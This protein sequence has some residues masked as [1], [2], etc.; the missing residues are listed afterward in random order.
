MLSLHRGKGRGMDR[1]R[2]RRSDLVGFGSV[3]LYVDMYGV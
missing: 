1:D 3:G 2:D